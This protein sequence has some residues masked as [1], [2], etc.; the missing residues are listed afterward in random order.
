[1]ESLEIG[2][3]ANFSNVRAAHENT[4]AAWGKA[5]TRG[6]A[7]GRGFPKRWSAAWGEQQKQGQTAELG[8]NSRS[9]GQTAKA[10]GDVEHLRGMLS[11]SGKG[12]SWGRSMGFRGEAIDPGDVLSSW[13]MTSSTSWAIQG[14]SFWAMARQKVGGWQGSSS[15]EMQGCNSWAMA[16]SRTWAMARRGS[17]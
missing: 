14:N 9:S 2:E 17:R 3:A 8:A 12:I 16:S 1:M 4:M 10:R 6:G 11:S 7:R 15:W 5:A 13:A